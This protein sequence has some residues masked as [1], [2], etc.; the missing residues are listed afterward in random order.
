MKAMR[1]PPRRVLI[2][3]VG[4]WSPPDRTSLG[5]G[6]ALRLAERGHAVIINT[7]SAVTD[8]LDLA[9]TIRERDGRA[10]TIQAD[11]S[12][13]EDVGR[14][15][16]DI[17]ERWGGLDA[18]INNAGT[19]IVKD[20]HDLTFEDWESQIAS[21]ATA[22]FYVSRA[23]LPFLRSSRGRIINIADAGAEQIRAR[24]RTLPYFVGKMGV[25]LITRTMAREEASHGVAV[26]AVLPGPL[27]NSDPAPAPHEIPAGRLGHFDDIFSAVEF[28]LDVAPPHITGSFVQV[29]GGWQL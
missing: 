4:A 16:R 14:L 24:P 20:Y 8:A 12:V 21:T 11:V 26:N 29:G 6:L 17:E 23:T 22:T 28:L 19:F 2:T 15:V 18:V 1:F 13:P 27:D 3:G 7:R 25:L 5:A 9:R 10:L